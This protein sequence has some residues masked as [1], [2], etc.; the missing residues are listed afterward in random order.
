MSTSIALIAGLGL[1]LGTATAALAGDDT[2]K[3]GAAGAAT[4]AVSA[5]APLQ[6]E[7]TEKQ[8]DTLT[9]RRADGERAQ[10]RTTDSTK[11]RG[12]NGDLEID[13]IETGDQVRV[14]PMDSAGEERVGAH[15]ARE[16]Q[17]VARGTGDSGTRDPRQMSPQENPIQGTPDNTGT[18]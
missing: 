7:V 11:V 18:R 1:V 12:Q 2:M 9:I 17:V 8:G 3:P 5:Q 13:D 10:V 14:T 4:G 16:I 15:V 6:G